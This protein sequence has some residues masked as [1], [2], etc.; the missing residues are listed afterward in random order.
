MSSS[1]RGELHE[2]TRTRV[3]ELR[4]PRWAGAG[5]ARARAVHGERLSSGASS[6]ARGSAL[7]CT[8]TGAGWCTR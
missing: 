5:T 8:A 7:S 1:P 2:L 6:A 4:S 3:A